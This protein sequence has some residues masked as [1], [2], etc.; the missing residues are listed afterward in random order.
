M[1]QLNGRITPMEEAFAVSRDAGNPPVR[2]DEAGAGD[3]VM[4]PSK[5]AR[6]RKRE[7]QPRGSLHTTAPVPDPTRLPWWKSSLTKNAPSKRLGALPP[8]Q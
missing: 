7:T 4:E 2:F 1:P 5:R 8:D 6:S 3:G